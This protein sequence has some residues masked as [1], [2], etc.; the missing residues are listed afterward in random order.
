MY[1]TILFAKYF[2]IQTYTL[3]YKLVCIDEG[4]D[5]SYNEY[6][7]LK[8]IFGKETKF[9]IY[10][11]TNQ[12]LKTNVGINNWGDIC[13][14]LDAKQCYLNE[15][16]RN[17][18]RITNYCNNR[19]NMN[20]KAIGIKGDTVDVITRDDME[21]TINYNYTND[22][23]SKIAVI[24]SRKYDKKKF[25]REFMITYNLRIIDN[26]SKDKV[27]GI[28]IWYVDEAK[29]IEFD[30]VFVYIENMSKNEMY[31]AFTRAINKLVVV[32]GVLTKRYLINYVDSNTL[33]NN[34]YILYKQFKNKK[35]PLNE[36][37]FDMKKRYPPY[38]NKLIKKYNINNLQKLVDCKLHIIKEELTKKEFEELLAFIK[39]NVKIDYIKEKI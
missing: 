6:I 28:S 16:Y 31:V 19:L 7:L 9:N 27:S 26:A 3:S 11:D 24:I 23:R 30:T 14:L 4:Q 20:I 18:S 2:L 12:L 36:R 38:L 5:I 29:G 37:M 15:N 39:R 22:K 17:S 25:L 8:N 35:L 34:R 32:K 21:E 33:I 1:F 10:G 13:G